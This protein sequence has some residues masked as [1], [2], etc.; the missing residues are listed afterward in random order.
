MEN[1]SVFTYCTFEDVLNQLKFLQFRY[2]ISYIL[3]E[4]TNSRIAAGN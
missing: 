4:N 2:L 3:M 1:I